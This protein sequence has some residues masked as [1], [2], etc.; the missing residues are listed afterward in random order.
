[1]GPLVRIILRYG[2]GGFVG[3]QIGN[4]LASDP[5]VVFVASA[6]AASII[7]GGTE[8]FYYLAKRYGWKT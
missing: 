1:M 6:V 8:C 7:G 4:Q 3:Y 2:V 5:D